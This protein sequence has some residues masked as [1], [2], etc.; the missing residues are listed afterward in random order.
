MSENFGTPPR[1]GY[2]VLFQNYGKS[3][4][5]RYWKFPDFKLEFVIEWKVVLS[6]YKCQF[7]LCF[8]LNN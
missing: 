6:K 7:M 2:R 1:L 8:L 3:C 4:L 5:V